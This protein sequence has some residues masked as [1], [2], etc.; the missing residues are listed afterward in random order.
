[1]STPAQVG[2]LSGVALAVGIGVLSCGG[3][4]LAWADP[5]PSVSADGRGRVVATRSVSPAT[6]PRS[7]AGRNPRSAA[8]AGVPA[9]KIPAKSASRRAPEVGAGTSAAGGAHARAAARNSGF[10]AGLAAFFNNQTPRLS[11]SQGAQTPAGVVTGALNA[12]DPDSDQLTFAVTSQAAHGTA[13]VSADGSWTYVP[14]PSVALTGVTDSFEVTVSDAASGFA[15][16]GLAG[17]VHLLSFGLIGRRGDSS[18]AT[19]VVAVAPFDAVNTP[20]TGRPTIAGID[21]VTGVVSGSV[22]GS[23]PDGDSLSYAVTV[24][25]AK[26]AVILSA[27]GAFTYT[28]TPEART[29]AGAPDAT[30]ADR[31]DIFTVTVTD[32]RG[33]SAAVG[34]PVSISPVAQS[35]DSDYRQDMRAFVI[36]IAR[37]A[38][39][40]NPAFIVI[41]QNGQEL[42]TQNGEA[43]GPLAVAYAAAI[44]GQGREDLFYGY[45]FDNV[46]TPAAERNY[47]LEF[48]DRE[49]AAG[50]QVLVTDYA[51]SA[52]KV[53]NSYAQNAAHG[54]ISFAANH[55][56]LDTIP[57]RPAE[58][59]GVNSDDIANLAQARNF[60]YVL[61]PGRFQS[62]AGYLD[63]L[64]STNYDVLIIDAF[65]DDQALTAAEV[66]ALQT[67]ANGGR[68]LVIAYMSIGEAEDYRYY[69]QAGWRPGSPSWLD[70]ENPDWAGNYK[71]RYW[72][73]GWQDI[74]LSGPDAYLNRITAAGFDGVYLDL[75][76]AFE[77]FE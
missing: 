45:T 21:P 47:M 28:P 2:R 8:S 60:L 27:V 70:S 46:A 34:V 9:P 41:P 10:F 42:I 6:V 52:A 56:D 33:G 51:S 74:I 75:I 57:P 58:P 11:P 65:Y 59:V 31:S 20:P 5:D 7:W 16:H 19:V 13:T 66:A 14:A 64:A 49:E 48:L 24:S 61:D 25:P 36:D 37:Q 77:Y 69:W 35:P 12:V 39:L 18:S 3:T 40:V 23:D 30:A 1:M 29:A 76:D 54:F 32:G 72:E 53:D 73:Q 4:G 50:V 43:D 38:R 55:R 17:L 68:R 15:L 26:G 44:D 71:V 63:A 67:K 62:Q 22:N